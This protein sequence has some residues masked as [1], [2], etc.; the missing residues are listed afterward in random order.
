MSDIQITFA[1]IV[2]IVALFI[3]NK[4]PVEHRGHRR[5]ARRC[6]RRAC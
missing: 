1:V 6:G 5:G 2:A 4:L 3:W